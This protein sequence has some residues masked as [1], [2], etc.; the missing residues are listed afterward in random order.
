MPTCNVSEISCEI[1]FEYWVHKNQPA[2]VHEIVDGLNPAFAYLEARLTGTSQLVCSCVHADEIFELLQLFDLSFIEENCITAAHVAR[3]EVIVPFGARPVLMVE[4]QRDLH[5]Y[6]AASAGFTIGHGN[7]GDFTAGILTWW[8]KHATE[9]GARSEAAKTAFAMAP[10]SAGAERVFSM[11]K[12][13]FCSNQD[14]AL[15]DFIRGSMMLHCNNS[16]RSSE[17]TKA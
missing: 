5:L 13:L 14:S 12:T 4:L 7:V 11:L 6:V 15:A 16:K 10:N 2:R 8:K 3:L 1:S 9:V 17:A